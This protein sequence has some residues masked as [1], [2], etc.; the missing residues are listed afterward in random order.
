M[1]YTRARARARGCRRDSTQENYARVTRS[2]RP[3]DGRVALQTILLVNRSQVKQCRLGM[4]VYTPWP[5]LRRA[6]TGPFVTLCSAGRECR[7]WHD[8]LIPESRVHG[9]CSSNGRRCQ[10]SQRRLCLDW[11]R[12]SAPNSHGTTGS[13]ALDCRLRRT[14]GSPWRRNAFPRRAAGAETAGRLRKFNFNSLRISSRENEVSRGGGKKNV[15]SLPPARLFRRSL[16]RE[17]V[18]TARRSIFYIVTAI[19]PLTRL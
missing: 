2:L 11:W 10:G 15:T 5:L 4:Y 14:A 8:R 6:R 16:F 7:Y 18:S 12:P 3:I 17:R 19:A 1:I 9:P 13:P